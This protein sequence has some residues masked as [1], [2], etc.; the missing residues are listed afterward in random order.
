MVQAACINFFEKVIGI[1]IPI[2][3]SAINFD[4]TNEQ[5]EMLISNGENAANV[6]FDKI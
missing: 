3:I 5:K 1:S 2:K 6:Y 4:L